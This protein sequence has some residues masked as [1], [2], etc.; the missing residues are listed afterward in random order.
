MRLIVKHLGDGRSD[1]DQTQEWA[2]DK[3][4]RLKECQHTDKP[5]SYATDV[6]AIHRDNLEQLKIEFEDGDEFRLPN[7]QVVSME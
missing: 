6:E 1:G 7:V 5:L 2:L 3:N 4:D